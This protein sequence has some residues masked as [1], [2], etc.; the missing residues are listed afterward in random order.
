MQKDEIRLIY[1]LK[2]AKLSDL[3]LKTLSERIGQNVKSNIDLTNKKCS[4]FLPI[5]KMKEIDTFVIMEMLDSYNSIFTVSKSDSETGELTHYIFE[6]KE[7]LKENKWG[8]PEPFYGA[9]IKPIELD[10]VFVP[11]L[12][13][14]KDGHRV[15]YGKGFYD[16]FLAKC[17][18][19]CQFIGL[20]FFD[21]PIEITDITE[22]DIQLNK[23]I[24]PHHIYTFEK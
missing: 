18:N 14:D 7:Q 19:D 20:S 12:A 13:F 6:G 9:E 1:K 15:G 4:I 2:R 3:A 24:T 10:I 5:H 11:L 23:C 17:K 8:I 16:R 22:H 21:D